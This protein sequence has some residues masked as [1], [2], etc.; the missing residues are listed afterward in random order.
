MEPVIK[1][2]LFEEYHFIHTPKGPLVCKPLS[3]LCI[4]QSQLNNC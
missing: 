1:P 4:D 2:T 3:V